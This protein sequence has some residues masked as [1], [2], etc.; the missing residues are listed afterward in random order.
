MDSCI[1]SSLNFH[2]IENTVTTEYWISKISTFCSFDIH[3]LTQLCSLVGQTCNKWLKISVKFKFI[4]IFPRKLLYFLVKNQIQLSIMKLNKQRLYFTFIFSP[5]ELAGN[6]K[7]EFFRKKFFL[8][9]PPRPCRTYNW[10]TIVDC[11]RSGLFLG[12]GYTD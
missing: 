3:K 7:F 2:L 6:G 10:N 11:N 12:E 5:P 9:E 4:Q 1:N 8:I